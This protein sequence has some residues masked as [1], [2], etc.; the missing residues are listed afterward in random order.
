MP[1]FAEILH[2]AKTKAAIVSL[3]KFSSNIKHLRCNTVVSVEGSRLFVWIS[4]Y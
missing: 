1:S 4:T 3:Y 2:K